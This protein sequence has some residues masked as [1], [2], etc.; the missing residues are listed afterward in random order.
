MA[1]SLEGVEGPVA[2]L[3]EGESTGADGTDGGVGADGVDG[4]GGP[5]GGI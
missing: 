4:P 2:G 5:E 3:L 1:G